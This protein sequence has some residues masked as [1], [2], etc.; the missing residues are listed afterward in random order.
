MIVRYFKDSI[1]NMRDIGG[2]ECNSGKRI[3]LGRL[4]RSNLPQYLPDNDICIISKM[5]IKNI[6]DLRSLEEIKTKKSVFEDNKE[7]KVYH[8][9][10]DIGK[11]VPEAEELVSKSYIEMLTLQKKMKIIF[12]IL[13]NN[14]SVLYFCNAGKDR[15]GVVTALILKLLGVSEKNIVD[16]YMATKKFMKEPLKKYAAYNTK[17]LN[18][19]TPQRFYMENFLKEFEHKYGNIEQYLSL[20]GIRENVIKNIKEKFIE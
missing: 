5:G 19:I 13:G 20:I 17:I 10:I 2:Y 15:S 4:I 9:G 12:E 7:F 18:I 8:I 14:D 6:I 11:D 3:K 16:D 1:E